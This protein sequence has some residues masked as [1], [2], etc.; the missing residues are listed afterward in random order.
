MSN[1]LIKD[2]DPAEIGST[3][4][5]PTPAYCI[6]VPTLE[7][8]WIDKGIWIPDPSVFGGVWWGTVVYGGTQVVLVHTCFPATPGT[9]PSAGSFLGG[10]WSASATSFGQLNNRGEL[11]FS[12]PTTS[13]GVV[14]G[15]SGGD[16]GS[17]YQ[18]V[19]FGFYI[20]NGKYQVIE[21]GTLIGSP[22]TYSSS[23]VFTVASF[24]G[25]VGYFHSGSLVY[26][27][28]Q[29]VPPVL[30]ANA[31]LYL[32]G[33]EVD[34]ALLSATVDMALSN[35]SAN[36]AGI[37]TPLTGFALAGGANLGGWDV[38]VLTAL[39]GTA[40]GY[41]DTAV[42]GVLAPLHGFA[43]A[44]GAN[45]GGW[46][47]GMV[48]TQL[49]GYAESGLLAPQ[50]AICRGQLPVL[51]GYSLARPC[52]IATCVGTLTPLRGFA[53]AGGADPGGWE[54]FA[55]LTPL[56]GYGSDKFPN[57]YITQ[58]SG[59]SLVAIG[60][61]EYGVTYGFDGTLTT[62]YSISGYGG[63]YARMAL[64]H[65]T[66]SAS[67][68]LTT[69]GEAALQLSGYQLMATGTGVIL[70]RANLVY[71]GHY[72]VA[73]QF[74]GTAHLVGSGYS[75][76][77]H[78]MGGA[79]GT[80]ILRIHHCTLSAS[81]TQGN[82]G[83]VAGTLTGLIMTPEGQVRIHGPHFTLV[84]HG[85]NTS[86]PT[87]EAYSHTMMGDEKDVTGVAVTHYTNYPFDRIMRFNGK[88]YGVGADGLFELTGN[89]FDTTPIVSV[90]QTGES[91]L[92]EPSLKRTRHLYMSG[93]LSQDLGVS[94]I[95]REN[96]VD[97]Y[98]YDPVLG[99][100]RNTRVTLGRGLQARYLAFK[101]TNTDG[102]D[103]ELHEL[104]PE[105]DVLRRTA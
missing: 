90:V 69:L 101:F 59:Y 62:P 99:G 57:Y 18:D 36:C 58:L 22:T 96:E 95:A 89:L 85:F 86:S 65:C 94:V 9:P 2:T 53:L 28:T 39:T 55:T 32:S 3:G 37:L 82:Y 63:G 98:T 88:Y 51:D 81:G 56:T 76:S 103:F 33:D 20:S 45:A 5:A 34:N 35:V 12:V 40:A 47:G 6:D 77:A 17:V 4:T 24:G 97:T 19:E 91:D 14:I 30:V 46:D 79:V 104:A 66:L 54:D 44:N 71:G 68:T 64:T 102:Q 50:Y 42:A 84:A 27:S 60:H 16:I 75:L 15:L 38:G 21:M 70:G 93:R 100:A 26:T 67:G 7:P 105:V 29:F 23:D 61:Q 49:T 48:L 25:T 72:V 78:G 83:I 1:T 13:V 43:L 41:M 52:T 74:G 10:R 87:Y 73:G 80:A 92:G 11:Q 8:I 31:C